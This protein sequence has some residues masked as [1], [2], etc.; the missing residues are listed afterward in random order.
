ML[1]SNKF[2][3]DDNSN[4]LYKDRVIEELFKIIKQ[5]DPD[6]SREELVMLVSVNI[7]LEDLKE[8][9]DD[10]NVQRN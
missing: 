6:S 9:E 8:D 1:I 7:A 10:F 3:D 2:E 5:L 4:E